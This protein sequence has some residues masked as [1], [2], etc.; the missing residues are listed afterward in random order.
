MVVVPKETALKM[1]KDNIHGMSK[2]LG[3]YLPDQSTD[4]VL[5]IKEMAGYGVEYT[6]DCGGETHKVV[7]WGPRLEYITMNNH[8]AE[9]ESGERLFLDLGGSGA[10]MPECFKLKACHD[11]WWRYKD[12]TPQSLLA[13]K[14]I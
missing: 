14:H 4:Y 10:L 1:L 8:T 6:V 2:H 7:R 11:H 3:M 9:D 5:D 13:S 12:K